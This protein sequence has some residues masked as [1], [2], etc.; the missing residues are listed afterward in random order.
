M[1][2]PLNHVMI[3]VDLLEQE[4]APLLADTRY[5]EAG[6]MTERARY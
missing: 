1:R 4:L 5:I 3:V 6:R 2:T